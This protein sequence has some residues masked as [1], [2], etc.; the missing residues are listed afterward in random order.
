LELLAL[1]RF[2]IRKILFDRESRVWKL[3]F[4]KARDH[5]SDQCVCESGCKAK[6]AII[7]RPKLMNLFGAR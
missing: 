1:T 2:I 4:I 5:F 3:A 6:R 7:D